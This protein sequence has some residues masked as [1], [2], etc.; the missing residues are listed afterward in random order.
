MGPRAIPRGTRRL[1][2][3]WH[4]SDNFGPRRDGAVPDIVVLHYTAMASA[5]GARD[6]LCHPDA[7]VSAH[8]V[9]GRQGTVWQLVREDMRAWHAGLGA[10]GSITEVNSRSIGIEIANTGAEPFPEPQMA[11]LT[12]LG[13]DT[14]YIVALPVL[15]M[16]IDYTRGVQGF[17][18]FFAAV[19]L[20]SW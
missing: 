20:T 6:W 9:I 12:K 7:G 5:E 3:L 16:S 8:Y 13:D 4:P 14:F 17:T 2:P 19:L 15:V 18:L 10:W 1:T 11:A